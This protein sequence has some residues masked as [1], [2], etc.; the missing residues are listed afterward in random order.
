ML[1]RSHPMVSSGDFCRYIGLKAYPHRTRTSDAPR[2]DAMRHDNLYLHWKRI[3]D[4]G[5]VNMSDEF[6]TKML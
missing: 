1:L 2:C 5:Q 3:L 6:F 4:D